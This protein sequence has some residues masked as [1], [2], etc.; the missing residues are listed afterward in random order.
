MPPLDPE[1]Q[2]D[3]ELEPLVSAA[4]AGAASPTAP[5]S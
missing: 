2:A 4:G 1:A 3:A 5:Q